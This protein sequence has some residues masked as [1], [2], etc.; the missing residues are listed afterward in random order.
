[1]KVRKKSNSPGYLRYFALERIFLATLRG[2]CSGYAAVVQVLPDY[3]ALGQNRP[4]EAQFAARISSHLDRARVRL[5]VV[6]E[7]SQLARLLISPMF[8]GECR[9]GF[10]CME[11]AAA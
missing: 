8:S 1:M 5:I 6:T 2:S 4:D 9:E 10:F 3:E 11:G 7:D